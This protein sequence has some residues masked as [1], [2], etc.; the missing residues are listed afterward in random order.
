MFGIFLEEINHGV[1]GGLYAEMIR[2]RAFEGNTQPGGTFYDPERKIWRDQGGWDPGYRED[3]TGL[4]YWSLLQTGGAKGSM[5]LSD[6]EP[7]SKASPHSLKLEVDELGRGRIGIANEGYWGI[8]CVKGAK[9]KLTFYARAARGFK[10]ALHAGIESKDGTPCTAPVKF[11]WIGPKWKQYT[12]TLV[13]ARTDHR[14][15]FVIGAGAAGTVWFDFVSLLPAKTWRNLPLRPDVAQMIADLKPSFVR[16]PGGCATEGGTVETSY[17]WKDTIGPL[18][19]RKEV[20]GAWGYYRTHGMGFHEYLQFC[21]DIGADPLYVA[22]CGQTCV[23]R[24]WENVPMSEMGWVVQNSLD[25]LDYANAPRATK[26]G[27]LRAKA[28]HPK[29]FNMTLFGI[30]NENIR[31]EYEERYALVY[32]AVKKKYPNVTTIACFNNKAAPVDMVDDHRYVTT[33]WLMNTKETYDNYDRKAPKVY[34]GE[35][36]TYARDTAGGYNL[37]AGLTE[38]A[39]LMNLERNADVVR[40]VSYAPLLANVN[41][42]TGWH[43][44]INFD[45]YRIF[46]T[47]AYY[48]QKMYSWNRP[49][50]TVATSVTSELTAKEH[51][52]G[53]IGIDFAGLTAAIT[54]VKVEK[55]GKLLYQSDFGKEGAKGWENAANWKIEDGALVSPGG[56]MVFFGDPNWEDYS[57][58]LKMKWI[59]ARQDWSAFVI[60]FASSERSDNWWKIENGGRRSSIAACNDFYD[61]K[62]ASVQDGNWHDMKVEFKDGH[63]RCSLDGQVVH[64]FDLL[65]LYKFVAQAGLDEKTGDVLIKAVNTSPEPVAA[66]INL[67]GIDNLAPSGYVTVMTS[68]SVEDQNTLD[69]PRKVAPKT[70]KLAGIAPSFAHE[71]LPNSFSVIRIRTWAKNQNSVSVDRGPLTFSVKIGEKYVRSGGTDEWPAWEIF[72]TTPWNYGLVIDKSNPAKSFEVVHKGWPKSE[73]PV[74]WDA[75]PIE[76]KAKAE[77]IPNWAEN[78]WGLVDKL[79]PSPVKSDQPTVNITMI[80]MGAGRLRPSAI[81]VIGSGPD[82]HEWTPP[83][84]PVSSFLL[85]ST[86]YCGAEDRG[87]GQAWQGLRHPRV[88]DRLNGN[89]R[90]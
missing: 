87:A 51:L 3:P 59:E 46:G 1:D 66:T 68:K 50:Y 35:I 12:A 75:S 79:Q 7:L 83:E 33:R 10:G 2:N 11:G 18:T 20:F 21:E 39:Y 76:L 45:N 43:G 31:R 15:R 78:F 89:A 58:S 69:E 41:G 34:I 47:P 6:Q 86:P 14:A 40:M 55:D 90:C 36:S 4:P 23:W 57:V 67:A 38:A 32:N 27:K 16:F 5:T 61:G 30:G 8:N 62:P 44:C 26:W 73:Q 56:G 48:T 81:P 28:G 85:P 72:P 52:R 88:A 29:P 37:L 19:D 9:Y 42:R 13:G 74:V 49:S 53:R 82:A 24:F 71:F 64:D 70:S 77:K 65:P 80:P 60:N 25:S 17:N 63:I 54:D 22:F 84:E